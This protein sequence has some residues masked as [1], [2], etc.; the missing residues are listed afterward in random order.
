MFWTAN[1]GRIHDAGVDVAELGQAE[2]VGGVLGVAELVAGGLVDRHRHGVG[3]RI[4]TVARMQHDGLRML[5]VRRHVL[6]SLLSCGAARRGS[7]GIVKCP[8]P[9]KPRPAGAML[10][11]VYMAR[12]G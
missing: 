3:R 5:A 11:G 10:H 7:I 12:C 2:Q 6:S 1:V 4:A 8:R 9:G